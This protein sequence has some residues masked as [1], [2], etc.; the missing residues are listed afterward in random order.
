MINIDKDRM[1]VL[2]KITHQLF[3]A[4]LIYAKSNSL[5]DNEIML[6]SEIFNNGVK[7][8]IE[9]M[10]IEDGLIDERSSNGI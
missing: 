10:Y 3:K 7:K 9:S 4:L 5:K 1:L 6:I 2:E 8:T